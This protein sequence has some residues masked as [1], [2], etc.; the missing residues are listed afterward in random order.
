[1]DLSNEFDLRFPMCNY[2]VQFERLWVLCYSQNHD[3]KVDAICT[4]PPSMVECFNSNAFPTNEN[5]SYSTAKNMA[6]KKK[7]LPTRSDDLDADS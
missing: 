2:D 3:K 6:V 1:M 5:N 7:N 4:F